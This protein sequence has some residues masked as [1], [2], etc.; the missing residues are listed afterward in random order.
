MDN[1]YLSTGFTD[2]DRTQNKKAYFDCLNLL[3]SLEYYKECKTRSYEL[4]QLEPGIKVLEAGCGLG[5]DAFRMA[6]L[7]MPGGLI[8]GLDA[9]TVMI[10]KARLHELAAQLPVEFQTGD[11]K[12][13][14]FP[15]NSFARCRIDRVLQ[16]IP[17]PQK[18]VAELVRVLEPGGLLLAYDN[19]WKTFSVA[20]ENDE[21]TQAIEDLWI[22]SFVNS[23]I[24]LHLPGYFISAGLTDVKIYP[25]TSVITDLATANKVYNL[26][27]NVQKAVAGNLISA[28]QGKRWIEEL[29]ERDARGIF[30][31]S[32]TAYTVVGRKRRAG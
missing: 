19:D 18:A 23:R 29:I 26:R 9:S 24:G 20:S 11:I 4:L 2:V 13:L 5:D 16:H 15:D 17:Q 14:P 27:E 7:I 31:A 25:G 32:L 1:E 22:G 12:A 8:V 21:I 28:D 30:L 3:G 10:E 6:R